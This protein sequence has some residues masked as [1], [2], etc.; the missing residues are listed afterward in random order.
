MASAQQN[1][2]PLGTVD[3]PAARRRARG[4]ERTEPPW[5][6]TS[7][8]IN[9]EIKGHL[10]FMRKS[11]KRKEKTWVHFQT[12]HTG[13]SVF[14]QHFLLGHGGQPGN[15]WPGG[16]QCAYNRRRSVGRKGKDG[17]Q[18]GKAGPGRNRGEQAGQGEK[19]KRKNSK[20][21]K[22]SWHFLSSDDNQGEQNCLN[23]LTDRGLSIDLGW[24][25][26][27]FHIVS[28]L[29]TKFNCPRQHA[30]SL[31]AGEVA[32]AMLFLEMTER[33]LCKGECGFKDCGH[34]PREW[35]RLTLVAK[36]SPSSLGDF[37]PWKT[38]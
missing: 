31:G 3:R 11:L 19:T 1:D 21:Q 5:E 4:W 6:A 17:I 10:I 2:R 9:R 32:W 22:K 7:L 38:P 26:R 16:S 13:S 14:P 8:L 30:E 36:H 15:T 20:K 25:E 27:E 29:K 28:F 35:V 18:G 12:L 24:Y 33:E 23:S 37:N 34:V